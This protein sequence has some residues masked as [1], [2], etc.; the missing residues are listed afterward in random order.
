M[1][2]TNGDTLSSKIIACD[3]SVTNVSILKHLLGQSG[4]SNIEA[5]TDPREVLPSVI[6]HGCDLLLLD[7]EMPHLSGYEVVEQIRTTFPND[8]IPILILTGMKGTKVRNKALEGG[9][10]DFIN[11]PFDLT[12]V[13]LRVKNLLQVRESYKLQREINRKLEEKVARR[14]QELN[15]ATDILIQ[16][17]AMAGELRDHETGN[18]VVRVSKY[19]RV[20]ADAYGL[21]AEIA[22]IVEKAAPM[23]DIGKIGIPDAILL[24]PGK[25][26]AE[27]YEV[28]SP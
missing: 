2:S 16:R 9:A 21:P 4:Y 8:Y 12:E 26:T 7:L 6:E 19:S 27:E 1:L 22:Y 10:N 11:K 25:L 24:K 14:T 5:M 15:D 28:M 17:L 20:L 13:L 18:H 23:H 3:D